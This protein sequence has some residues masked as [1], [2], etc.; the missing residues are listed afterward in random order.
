[1]LSYVYI[2]QIG[3]CW[4]GQRWNAH[5]SLAELRT[6]PFIV[7]RYCFNS[8]LFLVASLNFSVLGRFLFI[9][10]SAPLSNAISG[11][12]GSRNRDPRPL[13]APDRGHNLFFWED[14][15]NQDSEETEIRSLGFSKPLRKPMSEFRFLLKYE[16]SK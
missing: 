11:V 3:V 15:K 2:R 16:C 8:S 4:G 12:A 1:M 9:L 6:T 5:V 13:G 10:F 7:V 14:A